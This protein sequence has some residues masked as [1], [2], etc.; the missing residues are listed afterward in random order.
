MDHKNFLAVLL[1]MIFFGK[2]AFLDAKL[3]GLILDASGITL[4]NKL[5]PKKQIQTDSPTEFSTD[6]ISPG[7]EI[8]Y[9]CNTAVDIESARSPIA[10]TE[11]NFRK[12]SYEVPGKFSVPDDKFYPPPKA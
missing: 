12:Y 8:D 11:S 7:F 5:C 1:V 9:L 3:P 6:N 2:M 4:V 10:H